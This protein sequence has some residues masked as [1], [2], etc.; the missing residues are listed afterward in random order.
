MSCN[1]YDHQFCNQLRRV[2][3]CILGQ[4]EAHAFIYFYVDFNEIMV[5][6]G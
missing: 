2:I 6:I 5:S 1:M 3:E 4:W